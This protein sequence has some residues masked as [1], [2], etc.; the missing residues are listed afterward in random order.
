MTSVAVRY[1]LI[2]LMV[3]AACGRSES[4]HTGSKSHV[5]Q[6]EADDDSCNPAKPRICMGD[7]VVACEAD[8][9]LGRRLRACHKGC[10]DGTCQRTCEDEDVKLIY[11]VDSSNDFL[12]FDPRKL[13]GDPFHL[14][15]KLKCGRFSGTPFSMSVDR[16]GTAWVVY[17]DG[18]LF[19]VSITD[20][21]CEPTSY[22]RGS[23]GSTTFGMGFA[24]DQAGGDTEKLFIASNSHANSLSSI[25]TEHALTPHRIGLLT[26]TEDRNPEL[27]GTSDAKLYGFYP[28]TAGSSF[29]QEIDRTSGAGVGR[30]WSVGELGPVDAYAFAQWGGAFYVFA[31]VGDGFGMSSNST[32]RMVDK[33]TGQFR[34]VM[35]HLPYRISGAGVSTC[36]PERDQ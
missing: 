24:T 16:N 21:S 31:T 11:V 15:G 28:V 32:V 13:P 29:V 5:D 8:G 36:A 18:A 4:A 35:E 19:K 2:A 3:A 26:A 20:A 25:D 10:K 1:V 23:S 9:H 33:T 22:V 14:I 30:Q 34:T 6:M 12:S 27:T 7:D 17:D